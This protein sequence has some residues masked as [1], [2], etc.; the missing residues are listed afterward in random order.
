[1]KRLWSSQWGCLLSDSPFPAAHSRCLVKPT[2]GG[3]RFLTVPTWITGTRSA[4]P[5]GR[6]I[7]GVVQVDKGT[8]HL[9]SKNSYTDFQIRAEF[10]V[11]SD[12][13]SGIF[14]RCADPQNATLNGTRTAEGQDSKYA[15]GRIA[16]QYSVGV[17]KFR[18]VQIKPL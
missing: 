1:M 18:K 11:D 3:S 12:A 13:N 7:D 10:W 5:I 16:L 4:T 2:R 15:S 6:L 8:G 14:I 17:V 9:V